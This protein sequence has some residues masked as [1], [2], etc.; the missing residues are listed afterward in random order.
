[1]EKVDFLPFSEEL[2]YLYP[3]TSYTLQFVSDRA[4]TVDLILGGTQLL[5]QSIASGLNRISITTPATLVD[6]KLTI[7]GLGANISEVVVTD[8]NREFAY[9]EGMKSVGECEELEVISI[10]KNLYNFD[11]ITF[12]FSH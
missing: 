10:N 9:F 4:I 7:N 6:N 8:T 2:V 11:F 1:M 3:S 5:A 12:T